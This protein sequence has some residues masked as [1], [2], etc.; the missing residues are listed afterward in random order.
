MDVNFLL[1]SIQLFTCIL[2]DWTKQE[3][4]DA[5]G[6][7]T[8]TYRTQPDNPPDVQTIQ[9]QMAIVAWQPG[10]NKVVQVPSEVGTRSKVPSSQSHA[11]LARQCLLT[12]ALHVQDEVRSLKQ[13]EVQERTPARPPA[14]T[15]SPRRFGL[16]TGFS[17]RPGAGSSLPGRGLP[18]APVRLP[19]C[20]PLP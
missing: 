1:H 18:A 8:F 5:E 14:R 17:S 7:V 9:K 10:P 6:V 20:S 19:P 2:Q 4:E 3:S 16:A 13:G 12:L 11:E 15:M